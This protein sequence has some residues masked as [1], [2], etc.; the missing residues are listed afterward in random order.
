MEL[1]DFDS[2]L[3]KTGKESCKNIRI[4]NIGYTTI[5]NI[6]DYKNICSV[7]PLHSI[8]HCGTGHFKDENYNK[9]LILDS[10]DKYE[11]AWSGMR[12]EIVIINGGK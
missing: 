1:K 4:C 12:S 11:E 5:K 2:S 7:N 9:Y 8:I 3:L 10:A 6:D